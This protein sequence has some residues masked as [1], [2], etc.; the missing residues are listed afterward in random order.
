MVVV[1]GVGVRM[2][3]VKVVLVAWVVPKIKCVDLK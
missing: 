1:A 2:A 3:G